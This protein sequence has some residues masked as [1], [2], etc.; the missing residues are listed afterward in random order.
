MPPGALGTTLAAYAATVVASLSV[1][2]RRCRRLLHF[3]MTEAKVLRP[4]HV[5]H[6]HLLA[7]TGMEP[8]T[9]TLT[10]VEKL[11]DLISCSTDM[12]W[13]CRRQLA[14]R[15]VSGGIA[16]VFQGRGCLRPPRHLTIAIR[17]VEGHQVSLPTAFLYQQNGELNVQLTRT[18]GHTCSATAWFAR[19]ARH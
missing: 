15:A 8:P 16:S 19:I 4:G 10:R 5:F 12:S 18:P 17:M 9:P 11:H 13:T 6:K 7:C 1:P 3:R 14:L 2:K